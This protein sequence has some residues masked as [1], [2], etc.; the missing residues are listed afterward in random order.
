MNATANN[1]AGSGIQAPAQ[2]GCTWMD[3]GSRD[4]LVEYT[5]ALVV[6]LLLLTEAKVPLVELQGHLDNFLCDVGV[7]VVGK[8]RHAR[9]TSDAPQSQP[10][11]DDRRAAWRAWIV[12]AHGEGLAGCV[13]ADP[14]TGDCAV[15]IYPYR[16]SIRHYFSEPGTSLPG[17]WDHQYNEV[18]RLKLSGFCA[19]EGHTSIAE[20]LSAAPPKGTTFVVV[21]DGHGVSVTLVKAFDATS[22]VRHHRSPVVTVTRDALVVRAKR[23]LASRGLLLRQARGYCQRSEVGELFLVDLATNDIVSTHVDL[24]QLSHQLGLLRPEE[25]VE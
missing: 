9:S 3:S 6:Q 1:P 17:H 2:T 4:A 15:C 14:R 13:Q 19:S 7:A 22:A 11:A 8:A 18:D 12:E 16:H 5:A 21:F 23:R 24:K 25:K 20:E 10:S